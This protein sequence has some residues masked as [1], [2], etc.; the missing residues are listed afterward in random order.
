MTRAW[1]RREGVGDWVTFGNARR[2][3]WMLEKRMGCLFVSWA[4]DGGWQEPSDKC[5]SAELHA[6]RVKLHNI[7]LHKHHRL[8]LHIQSFLLQRV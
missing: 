6:S 7:T 5:S 1:L 8:S 2:S 3:D 4:N